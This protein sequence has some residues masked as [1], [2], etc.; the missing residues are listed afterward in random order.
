MQDLID[1]VKSRKGIYSII[2]MVIGILI[3][4]L[5]GKYLK[6]YSF[7]DFV[8]IAGAIISVIGTQQLTQL[9]LAKRNEE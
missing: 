4:T 2:T 5:G 1:V 7:Y 3:S 6:N 8:V 9:L